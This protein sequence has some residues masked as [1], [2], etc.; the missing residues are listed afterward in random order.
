[1]ERAQ[2]TG[3]KVAHTHLRYLNPLPREMGDI[4][5]RYERILVPELNTGQLLLLLRGR[6]GMDNIVGLHKVN[7]RPFTISEIARKIHEMVQAKV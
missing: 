2:A 4:L 3:L 7:G 1:V 6:F 5:R